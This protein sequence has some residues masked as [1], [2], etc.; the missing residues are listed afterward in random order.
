M[1]LLAIRDGATLSIEIQ[2]TAPSLPGM[3]ISSFYLCVSVVREAVAATCRSGVK[4]GR[5]QSLLPAFEQ[6]S[7]GPGQLRR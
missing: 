2:A 3:N 7:R 1:K 6:A 5:R 4:G